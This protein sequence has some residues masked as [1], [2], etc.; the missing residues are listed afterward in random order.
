MRRIN[1]RPVAVEAVLTRC[2]TVVGPFM[3]ELIGHTELTPY[4]GGWCGN[5][6]F[7]EVADRRATASPQPVGA[8][9]R[10]PAGR[11][12]LPGFFEVDVLVDTDADEVTSASSTPA[13]AGRRRSPTSPPAPTPTCRCSCSTSWSTWT[14]TSSSTSTRSTSAGRSW[15]S[16]DLWSQMIIKETDDV[17]ERLTAVRAPVSYSTT[18]GTL[19]FRRAALDWHQLQN[20]NE[21]FFLR[22][23][24]PGDYRW[25]GADLGVL[26]TKGRLQ[27]RTSATWVSSTLLGSAAPRPSPT[28]PPARTR[29]CRSSRST[30]W[31]SPMSSSTWTSTRSTSVGV[32]S[33]PSTSGAT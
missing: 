2:G 14:S 19:V 13:S 12:G 18:P 23:Y 30:Y 28:S 27:L 33:P 29:T 1:N 16:V 7:P 6:M 21:A 10:R 24:G 31:S 20:E 11:G 3:S 9:A 8:P 15:P 25:K 4:E 5:E 17:V 22:I 32:S 26:V